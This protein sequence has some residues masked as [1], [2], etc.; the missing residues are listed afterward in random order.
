MITRRDQLRLKAPAESKGR[1]RGRGRGKGCRPSKAS[2]V[3]HGDHDSKDSKGA[4]VEEDVPEDV[5]IPTIEVPTRRLRGKSRLNLDAA[6]ASK[7]ITKSKP[8]KGTDKTEIKKKETKANK[9]TKACNERRETKETGRK[10]SRAPDANPGETTA[11]TKRKSRSSVSS[12]RRG[13]TVYPPSERMIY[14][15]SK[16]VSSIDKRLEL[17]GLKQQ[18]KDR[19][20]SCEFEYVTFTTYWARPSCTVRQWVGD[21]WSDCAY[22]GWDVNTKGNH[23]M[24]L[25]IACAAAVRCVSCLSSRL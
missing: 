9:R 19:I 12:R 22:F 3:D 25:V 11:Q 17:D 6:Q 20:A 5:T 24:M 8:K 2:G 21:D 14:T 15:M 4:D 23:H 1:G 18:I 10:R 7:V 16:F 13:E